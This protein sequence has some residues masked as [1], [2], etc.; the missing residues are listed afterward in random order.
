MGGNCEFKIAIRNF[1][2]MA[3]LQYGHLNIIHL[4]NNSPNL[5]PFPINRSKLLLFQTTPH[6]IWIRRFFPRSIKRLPHHNRTQPHPDTSRHL[7][8]FP[9][10]SNLL[11]DA[12]IINRP[13]FITLLCTTLQHMGHMYLR[14]LGSPSYGCVVVVDYQTVFRG[15]SERET[16][17]Y[18]VD[19]GLQTVPETP[20]RNVAG[21]CSSF[22]EGG[23][24]SAS[25]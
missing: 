1:V 17:D 2:L 8:E 14:C 13:Q 6:Q 23:G 15:F 20:K 4:I 11:Y 12:H 19:A 25:P 24:F 16:N 10:A 7:F 22:E 5:L 18:E 9:Q 3:Y 21:E